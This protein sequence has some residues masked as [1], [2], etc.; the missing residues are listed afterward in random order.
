MNMKEETAPE[1]SVIVPVFREEGG[2]NNFLRDLKEK[3][4][5]TE[6]EIIVVDGD[7]EERTNQVIERGEAITIASQQGRAWQM[8]AGARA[9]RGDILLFLH[10]DTTLPAGGVEAMTRA[11]RAGAHRCGAFRLTLEGERRAYRLIE[12]MATIRTFLSRIPFG[13]Q[14]IFMERQLFGD[15]GEYR[16]IPLMED[17]ELM[18]RVKRAGEPVLLMKEKVVTSSRKWQEEG[19]LYTTLRNWMIQLRYYLGT[20]PEKLVHHYY[21]NRK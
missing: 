7:P 2:I 1:V 6:A 21:K 14:A 5:D 3:L 10:A 18:Q 13:D 11:L 8:N 4:G 20:P 15:L 19:A 12:T 16:E 9:A 17:V